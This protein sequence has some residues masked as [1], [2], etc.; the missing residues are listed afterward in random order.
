M[1]SNKRED[2]ALKA[3]ASSV[4]VWKQAEEQTQESTSEKLIKCGIQQR[5]R[6]YI[7]TKWLE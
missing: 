4:I 6:I 7:K 5:E 1:R 3:K 2:K